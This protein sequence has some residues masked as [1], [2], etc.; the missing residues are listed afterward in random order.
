[1]SF[2]NLFYS[3]NNTCIEV[4]WNFYQLPREERGSRQ[5]LSVPL[6]IGGNGHCWCCEGKAGNQNPNCEAKQRRDRPEKRWYRVWERWAWDEDSMVKCETSRWRLINK[7][8]QKNNIVWQLFSKGLQWATPPI[9]HLFVSLSHWIRAAH[10]SVKLP[11]HQGNVGSW[12][13]FY[14][15]RQ[16][17][18]CTLLGSSGPRCE[19]S[20]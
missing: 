6:E 15:D 18:L 17:L 8:K 7:T 3:L 20:S 11:R 9:P 13:R 10:V 19:K 5:E 16:P 14:G 4:G 2:L 1:M 12:P